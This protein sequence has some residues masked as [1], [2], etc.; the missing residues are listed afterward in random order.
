MF[1]NEFKGFQSAVAFCWA[2]KKNWYLDRRDKPFVRSSCLV[3]QA[4][5][6]AVEIS[7]RLFYLCWTSQ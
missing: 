1:K 4:S 6:N 7:S 3:W 2:D 5:T